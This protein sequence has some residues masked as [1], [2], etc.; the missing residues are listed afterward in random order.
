[1][2]YLDLENS[3]DRTESKS[4][5]SSYLIESFSIIAQM[6]L[7]E[8]SAVQADLSKAFESFAEGRNVRP[9]HCDSA[10]EATESLQR[11]LNG[12]AGFLED[13]TIDSLKIIPIRFQLLIASH[14][15]E[16]QS[17]DLTY[18]L[19]EFRS[20]CLENTKQAY[21]RRLHIDL[22]LESLKQTGANLQTEGKALVNQIEND[23]CGTRNWVN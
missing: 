8:L 13:L 11:T 19:R 5:N 2:N 18:R 6:H 22:I 10:I 20:I 4:R 1:M 3:L 21:K 14:R 16:E 7:A 12:L 15:A 17:R 23:G 9:A